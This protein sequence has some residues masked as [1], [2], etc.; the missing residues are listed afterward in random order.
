[1]TA[2]TTDENVHVDTACHLL[3]VGRSQVTSGC[4]R[5]VPDIPKTAA[6]TDD[7]DEVTCPGDGRK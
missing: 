2:A 5:P 1:M 6:V 7:P 3:P 4:G